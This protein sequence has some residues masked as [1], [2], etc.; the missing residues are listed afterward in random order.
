MHKSRLYIVIHIIHENDHKH[1]IAGPLAHSLEFKLLH[2]T[3]ASMMYSG[4]LK[5][6]CK[7][8]SIQS[9]L[10]NIELTALKH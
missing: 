6:D 8:G 5:G 10:L 4:V 1:S 2:I 3:F 7:A 9:P